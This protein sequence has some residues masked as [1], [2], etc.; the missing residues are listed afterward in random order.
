MLECVCEL[1]VKTRVY[2]T[3]VALVNVA[4]P[5][6]VAALLATAQ[7]A[8]SRSLR[9]LSLEH[10]RARILLRFL[11]SCAAVRAVTCSSAFALLVSLVR[12]AAEE[13]A[14]ANAAAPGNA[15]W[16]PRCDTLVYIA[17]AA[18]PFAGSELVEGCPEGLQALSEQVE[19]YLALRPVRALPPL[20][21]PL[22]P[23]PP[24][25][26]EG[27]EAPAPVPSAEEDSLTELWRR[28]QQCSAP[29]GSWDVKNLSRL[30][31]AAKPFMY[32]LQS[33][34]TP[35]SL[36][37]LHVPPLV[38]ALLPSSYAAALTLFPPRPRL[39]LL[40]AALTEPPS[41]P[42]GESAGA[43][44][45]QPVER[46]T[47]EE[48]LLD[49]LWAWEEGA[50]YGKVHEASRQIASGMPFEGHSALLA[51]TLFAAALQLPQ[52]RFRPCYYAV[53]LL[54]LTKEDA[55]SP[56]TPAGFI[57]LIGKV[58]NGLFQALTRTPTALHPAAADTLAEVFSL[59]LS[60]TGLQWP[61]HRWAAAAELHPAHPQRRFLCDLL[62]RLAR[63][64]Y[65]SRVE[66]ALP[67]AL[68]PLLGPQPQPELGWRYGG[69]AAAQPGST[70]GPPPAVDPE[71]EPAGSGA[72]AQQLLALAQR[73]ASAEEFGAA[74]QSAVTG[75]DHLRPSAALYVAGCVLA[76]HGRKSITHMTVML[77]R[78]AAT[79][80]PAAD[81][82][83]EAGEGGAAVLLGAFA[84]TA[85][86][87][88]AIG[89]VWIAAERLAAAGLLH[90]VEAVGWAFGPHSQRLREGT[91][92]AESG[93]G[94]AVWTAL[95]GAL[96]R[97]RT[98][99]LGLALCERALRAV[100]AVQVDAEVG[101]MQAF[102]ASQ[103]AQDAPAVD[104]E[105]CARLT[106]LEVQAVARLEEA[107]EAAAAAEASF[108]ACEADF[109]G[110]VWSVAGAFSASCAAAAARAAAAPEG[111]ERE[112]ALVQHAVV[113]DAFRSFVARR[114]A[115]AGAHAA[116][117]AAA[118]QA[119]VPPAVPVL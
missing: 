113:Y 52:P 11:V 115:D 44:P 28:V 59:H 46:F 26:A 7:R 81:T 36:P 92:G 95:E 34:S 62:Q 17:L 29:G 22:V 65:W 73:K 83:A 16:Q 76:H 6:A 87:T 4:K 19:A 56:G 80:R 51:E 2:S 24:A 41:Q 57:P 43:A 50:S 33:S 70:T 110:L 104:H 23:A 89:G 96:E 13:A 60:A 114:F 119:A 94:R 86:R 1:P 72:L 103:D 39:R 112:R 78:Y 90:T 18:L 3:L 67:E 69:P 107:T 93:G 25:R 102:A 32:A 98:R 68:K 71:G 42:A 14:R 77:D 100:T 38:P 12:S 31:D 10:D 15:S 79:L 66:Q 27:E 8:L 85:A 82:V 45:P 30:R 47:A 88:G 63:L 106:Q 48:L 101:Q 37:A 21:V 105:L 35:H 9:L 84:D 64:A 117:V 97:E 55:W 75:G 58:I 109:A 54:D 74:M 20:L 91:L 40:D 99:P 5:E 111:E 61:W 118:M 116:E 108:R 49:N 53:V